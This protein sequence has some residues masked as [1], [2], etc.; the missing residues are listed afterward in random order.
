MWETWVQS[1]GWEDPLVKGKATHSRILACRIPWT[2]YSM[3]LQ[4]VRHD[5]STFTK[6]IQS[7][8][9]LIKLQKYEKV[10]KWDNLS[11]NKRKCIATE[12]PCWSNS[13]ESICQCWEHEYN[14]WY[15]KIPHVLVQ[16]SPFTTTTEPSGQNNWSPCS[17]VQVRQL[18]SSQ[19][20]TWEQPSLTTTR[21]SP[22]RC[23]EQLKYGT[24]SL[25]L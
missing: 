24:L 13:K 20:T 21:D 4:R 6:C 19:A 2:V 1:L 23:L 25:Q 17:R 16:L 8:F 11:L 12:F 14:S 18:L 3:G 10:T 22:D 9:L 5:W 7:I 15:K